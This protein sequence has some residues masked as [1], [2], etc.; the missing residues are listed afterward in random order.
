MTD[1]APILLVEDHPDAREGL[2]ALLEIEGFRVEAA[3][4]GLAAIAALMA[5]LRPC[6]IL[7]DLDL[8]VFSGEAFRRV[9][10][11]NREFASIPVVLVS[12][13][14]DLPDIAARLQVAG[15]AAKPIEVDAIVELIRRQCTATPGA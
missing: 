3:H 4:D 8:P 13:A 11:E 14:R 6:V 9:Q 12:G 2:R 1:T 5:G 10:L 15:Y 7:L